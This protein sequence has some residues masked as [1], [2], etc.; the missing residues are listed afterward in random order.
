MAFLVG[1]LINFPWIYLIVFGWNRCG[2]TVF[3]NKAHNL[4]R[5]IGFIGNDIHFLSINRLDP[6]AYNYPGPP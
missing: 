5:I 2:T 4:S 6:F 1:V 3:H